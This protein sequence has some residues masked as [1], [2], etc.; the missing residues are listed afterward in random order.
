MTVNPGHLKLDL[1]AQG[2]RLSP[3]AR[4]QEDLARALSPA[5]GA[6]RG[7]ELFLPGDLWASA[8]VRRDDSPGAPYTLVVEGDH[9][10]LVRGP[11]EPVEVRI[12]PTPAFY[13]A[14]TTQ[15]TPMWRISR[16]HGGC[17][18]IRPGSSCGFALWGGPC[19]F[20]A[21]GVHPGADT[22]PPIPVEEVVEV[23]RAAFAEGAAEFV[24][25]N[26]GATDGDDRGIA[27]LEPYVRAIKRH[28]D[29]LVAVQIHPPASNDWIDQT[30][31]N[32]VDAL[33]YSLEIHDPEV[34]ARRCAG[35]AARIGRER[36]HEA[37]RYAAAIFPSGTVWSDLV[38]GLEPE[39]STLQ[40]IDALTAIGVL[41]VLSLPTL[42]NGAPLLSVEDLVPVFAHLFTA[43]RD[44]R[45]N[46]GWV[47]DLSFAI[48]PLEARFFA[49]D[50]ARM[51]VAMQSFYRT[52]VGSLA[53]RNLSRLRRRLRVR[54]VG[55]S[56]DSSHL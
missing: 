20:C 56:F 40:G 6:C 45:I 41:P 10:L 48:T 2:L 16:V 34:L 50:D 18:V 32:G 46:M 37:L 28:F 42:L 13:G 31:A 23:V 1:A 11:A 33:S 39:S 17:L 22:P 4:A 36:Y 12:V 25:F 35:R 5:M 29:T 55:D 21:A 43:V 7:V 44:A 15:G 8:P 26:A 53:A 19:A 49:G 47:R 24:Y 38:V 52:R 51:A 30:Y 27:F 14:Q 3:S 54:R 9:H